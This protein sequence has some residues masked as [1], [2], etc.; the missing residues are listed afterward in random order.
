M[1]A[2]MRLTRDDW[3]VNVEI[4]DAARRA[5]GWI[6][7]LE[8]RREPRKGGK[9]HVTLLFPAIFFLQVLR[10]RLRL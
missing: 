6:G 5:G 7:E 4:L 2:G 10:L 3:T 9:S 1:L 8:V